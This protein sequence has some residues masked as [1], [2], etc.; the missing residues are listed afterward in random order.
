MLRRGRT[1]GVF[2]AAVGAG[3]AYSV[4]YDEFPPI[5]LEKIQNLIFGKKDE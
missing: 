1:A 2:G 5:D 3:A 4:V